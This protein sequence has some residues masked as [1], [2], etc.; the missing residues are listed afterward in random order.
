MSLSTRRA[1][2]R[3]RASRAGRTFRIVHIL[4]G[5]ADSAFAALC[6]FAVGLVAIRSLPDAGVALFSLMLT[7]YIIGMIL[8]RNIVLTHV[9]LVANRSSEVFV[10]RLRTSL[11]FTVGPL[12]AAA[13]VAMGSGV[14][15][16]G[17]VSAPQYA[18]MALGAG[19]A[20]VSGAV[21]AHVR[22]TM[23]VV[24]LHVWAGVTSATN[25]VVT[26]TALLLGHAYLSGVALWGL[27]FGALAL[28]QIVS[29]GWWRHVVSRVPARAVGPATPLRSRLLYLVPIGAA[30]LAIYAQSTL[31]VRLLGP[32]QSAHLESA[33]VAASPV[34]ILASGLGALLLPP[35]VRALATASVRRTLM[36]LARAM[37]AVTAAGLVYALALTGL[38]PLLGAVFGR[39]VDAPLAAARAAA[40]SIDGPTSMNLN[41]L[42]ALDEFS[43]PAWVSVLSAIAGVVATLLLLPHLGLFSV[44]F[45]Q[46][47]SAVIQVGVGLCIT[48]RIL[49]SREDTRDQTT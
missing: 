8:P 19:V 11:L 36:G 29:L 2:G 48:L 24:R 1:G 37:G 35:L 20:T 31:V 40:F 43:R 16:W 18:A 26:V 28:G 38:G 6:T 15:V 21:L 46:A 32:S 9:E 42:I 12:I 49:R 30:Q 39:V 41:M 22:A 5:L 14:P 44:P 23:H 47:L 4:G 3:H 13:F 17:H 7:G 34:Y 10:P 33:R 45:G 25:V 27:P